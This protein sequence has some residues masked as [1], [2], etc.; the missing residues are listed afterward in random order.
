MGCTD[1]PWSLQFLV[2]TVAGGSWQ[3]QMNWQGQPAGC[4]RAAAL[5]HWCPALRSWL[6]IMAHNCGSQHSGGGGRKTGSL[7]SSSV[8]QDVQGQPEPQETLF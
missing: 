5:T 1:A 7:R 3:G 2:V 4:M 6:V 8:S